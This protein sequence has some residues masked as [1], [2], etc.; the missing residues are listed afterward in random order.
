MGIF[1]ALTTAITGLRTQSTALEHISNNIANSQTVGFKRT[2][3]SF[4]E[5]VPDSAP[6][7]QAPG[8]VQA[9]SRATNTVQGDVSNSDISTFVAING[10][11]Y[12]IVGEQTGTADGNPVFSSE[13]LYT[14][15]GDFEI[16]RFG[17]L[18]NGAGYFLK[19]LS[20]NTETGNIAGSVPEIV[21]ISNDFLAARA[22]TE[23]DYRVN[24]P[25]FP[26]TS[27]QS[28]SVD[29]SE[30]LNRGTT[31]A[32]DG[33]I[34]NNDPRA[35][36]DGLVQGQDS[37]A[38]ISRSIAGGAITTFDGAG[39]GL[40]V[41]FRWAKIDSSLNTVSEGTPPSTTH[42][43]VWNLFYLV[44]GS[45]T[46]TATA[47]NNVGTDYTFGTNGLLNPDITSVAGL[48]LTLPG[49]TLTGITIDHGSLGITQFADANGTSTVNTI[50]QD[51]YSAGELSAVSITDDGEVNVSYS[52]GESVNIAQITLATF[53]SDADLQK[54]DGGSFRATQES[55]EPIL[56][57]AGAVVGRALEASNTDIADEFTKL[58]VTQ[59]A[60]SANTR[61]ITTA[62]EILQEALNII[63]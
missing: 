1:G 7:E 43:D 45:A 40:N 38:F 44:D 59:Q 11:G 49:G 32:V 24:L 37:D 30:L 26:L 50:N 52:N 5:L 23:V 53:N 35:S 12:F 22:T 54:L 13:D 36:G 3:T 18:K 51:G 21:T 4:S 20:I 47:W 34:F 48:T 33:T 57:G 29:F 46:G 17:N 42:N 61:I 63:R 28:D 10:D 9:F 2:D 15:R 56:S 41:Q 55:G 31:G 60:Y 25:S 58:I 19:G 27:N 16:D 62:D 8:V 6:R 14:R 39:Q